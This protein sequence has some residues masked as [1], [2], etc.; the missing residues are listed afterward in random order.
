MRRRSQATRNGMWRF[1]W[2]C[3]DC[4]WSSGRSIK[5]PLR[6]T[7]C[8]MP[9]RSARQA[10][11]SPFSRG[12]TSPPHKRARG[13]YARHGLPCPLPA[14]PIGASGLRRQASRWRRPTRTRCG[15]ATRTACASRLWLRRTTVLS[16]PHP[17]H[18]T[19]HPLTAKTAPNAPC[20]PH[21]DAPWHA[22]EL[23]T[24]H[25]NL[26]PALP[27]SPQSTGSP[28]PTANPPLCH[29]RLLRPQRL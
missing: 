11:T 6:C 23:T 21:T 22:A 16:T 7:T 28:V 26:V 18:Q 27:A 24:A 9:M 17:A 15:F 1:M 20:V 4:D 5:T 13:L 29:E 10:R 3:W 8:F 14:L 2:G 25:R 19:L 12:A